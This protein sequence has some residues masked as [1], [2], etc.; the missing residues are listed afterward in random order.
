MTLNSVSTT[1]PRP[2]N[3]RYLLVVL[4]KRLDER[5][6]RRERAGG[7]LGGKD[8]EVLIVLIL[9]KLVIR[10]VVILV[11]RRRRGRLVGDDA[12]GDVSLRRE[13]LVE[14]RAKRIIG[15]RGQLVF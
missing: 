1:T 15:R 4:Q 2:T 8:D 12:T 13:L 9:L 7:F 11:I 10:F 3:V 6:D 5:I 14:L